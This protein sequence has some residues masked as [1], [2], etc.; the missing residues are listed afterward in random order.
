MEVK[1]F[2][3]VLQHFNKFSGNC[4]SK[5]GC[6]RRKIYEFRRNDKN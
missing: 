4:L 1:F 3:S 2:A 5:N 6:F